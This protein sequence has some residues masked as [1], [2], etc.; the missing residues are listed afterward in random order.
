M[1]L[2]PYFSFDSMKDTGVHLVGLNSL[3]QIEDK[4]NPRFLILI[5]NS[6]VKPTTTIEDFYLNMRSDYIEIS[7]NWDVRYIPAEK[8][9]IL[10]L[11]LMPIFD[12]SGSDDHVGYVKV[13]FTNDAATRN[14]LYFSKTID[15]AGKLV[16]P[17]LIESDVST[18]AIHPMNNESGFFMLKSYDSKGAFVE[19]NVAAGKSVL[20]RFEMEITTI[21]NGGAILFEETG[22]PVSVK[23]NAT[24]K[25]IIT[26]NNTIPANTAISKYSLYSAGISRI[27]FP[28]AFEAEISDIHIKDGETLTSIYQLAVNM[29][30]LKT[31]NWD[32]TINITSMLDAFKDSG[33]TSFPAIDLSSVTDSRS[34]FA[35]CSGLTSLPT[36]ILPNCY[37]CN[38]MF[39]SCVNLKTV[40]DFD[41]PNVVHASNMFHDCR[42]LTTQGS[43]NAPKLRYATALWRGCK[44]LT[45]LGTL[46]FPSI[47]VVGWM[48]A[49]THKLTKFPLRAADLVTVTNI[50]YWM[51]SSGILSIPANLKL[52]LLVGAEG[53]FQNMQI[54]SFPKVDMPLCTNFHATFAGCSKL[55]TMADIDM[56]SGTTFQDT[57]SK[58]EL[59]TSIPSS[60]DFSKVT[61]LDATFY[62]CR[63]ITS[64]GDIIAPKVRKAN[65]LFAYNSSL[66]KVGKIVL[67]EGVESIGMFTNN[68]SLTCIGGISIPKIR[69]SSRMFSGCT[70]LTSP[71][72][73]EQ[74]KIKH[75]F[76]WTNTKPCP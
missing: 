68:A 5:G 63:K 24:G 27:S 8:R 56:S 26:R 61:N 44:E 3:V 29:K 70:A 10:G 37:K 35:S 41:L 50:G 72:A 47:S 60:I 25:F 28:N 11:R 15:S 65:N 73:A 2:K 23:D 38:D 43:V 57:F 40:P 7:S 48:F 21:A 17:T 58:C 69:N 39:I 76:S 59:L 71:S 34:A 33:I 9:V 12:L 1:Q 54:T 52:P 19:S 42:S 4:A 32:G 62:K 74:T 20:S 16:S 75:G 6:K 31:F 55:V 30:T 67:D 51:I 13:T 36:F 53:G 49:D 18:G 22:Y 64:F 66:T 14:D 46:S 45:T